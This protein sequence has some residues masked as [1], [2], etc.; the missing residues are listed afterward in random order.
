V[1]WW[2]LA[3][4][5]SRSIIIE[6]ALPARAEVNQGKANATVTGLQEATDAHFGK[7]DSTSEGEV[8]VVTIDVK[9]GDQNLRSHNSGNRDVLTVGTETALVERTGYNWANRR[10]RS[11][12]S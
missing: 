12:L 7:A 3:N 4:D 6:A 9:I 2:P 5:S 8:L 1:G 10:R 11:P